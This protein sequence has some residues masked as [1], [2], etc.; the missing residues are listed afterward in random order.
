MAQALTHSFRT[1]RT[2]S[3]CVR[4]PVR[5]SAAI[6]SPPNPAAEPE[7]AAGIRGGLG[8]STPEAHVAL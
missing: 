1:G 5:D 3:G 7:P 6:K 4:R 2:A 8:V